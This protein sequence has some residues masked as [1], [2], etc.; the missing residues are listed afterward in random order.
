MSRSC[1][2]RRTLIPP[3]KLKNQQIS[4]VFF[5]KHKL[6]IFGKDRHMNRIILASIA[7]MLIILLACGCDT[8][9][10]PERQVIY[11]QPP[12]NINPPTIV[13]QS[14]PVQQQPTII[15]PQQQ[16]PI[17]EM[18]EHRQDTEPRE[19]TCPTCGGTG[20]ITCTACQGRGLVPCKPCRGTG[21]ILDDS[22]KRVTCTWCMGKGERFCEACSGTWSIKGWKPCT[23]CGGRGV[24]TRGY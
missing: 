18:R 17:R 2:F 8:A 22:G 7:L 24:I 3:C 13:Y 20:K 23:R 4:K 9:P 1:R 10:P 16:T 11:V 19:I 12:Q 21:Y 5:T 6:T 14:P 15:V